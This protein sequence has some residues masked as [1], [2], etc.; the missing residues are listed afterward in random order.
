MNSGDGSSSS[1]NHEVVA[2]ETSF[3]SSP[4]GQNGHHFT[5][6]IFKCIPM[7]EKFYISIKI[8][9]KLVPMGSIDNNPAL[10]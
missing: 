4:P 6:V 9:L 10:V 3:N 5:D 1:T 2:D 8:L 7:N